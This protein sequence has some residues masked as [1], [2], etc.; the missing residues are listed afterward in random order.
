MQNYNTRNV[1]MKPEIKELWLKALRS[2]DY[3]KGRTQLRNIADN[4]F[5]CLGVLCDLYDNSKWVMHEG[6]KDYAY[7]LKPNPPGGEDYRQTAGL[8]SE[9]IDWSGVNSGLGYFQEP[10]KDDITF[11]LAGINDNP[12]SQGFEEVIKTIEENF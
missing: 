10:E 4:S 8:S 3:K 2:G 1:R 5:C 9:V 12:D 7:Q 6:T 11:S